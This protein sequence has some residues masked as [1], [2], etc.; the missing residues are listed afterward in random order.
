MMNVN[1]QDSQEP[2]WAMYYNG[3]IGRY[4]YAQDVASD[5]NGNVYVV[6]YGLES[7]SIYWDVTTLKYDPNGNLLWKQNYNSAW[8]RNDRGYACTVD[9]AG[10]IYVLGRTYSMISMDDFL[11]IKYDTNGNQQWVQT[12][13]GPGNSND[14]VNHYGQPIRYDNGRI[15]VTGYSYSVGTSY[16]ATT[17]CYDANS[18]AQ[19][20][21]HRYHGGW[22]VDFGRS[23]IISGG[24]CYITGLANNG[25]TSNDVLT[26]CYNKIS[27]AVIWVKTY[28][29]GLGPDFGFDITADNAGRVFVTG[30]IAARLILWGYEYDRVTIAYDGATGAQLWVRTFNANNGDN[31]GYGITTD[32][33]GN[34]YTTGFSNYPTSNTVDIVTI[35][36]DA[37]TGN[38]RWLAHYNGPQTL[39]S[40]EYSY[41]KPALDANGNV[42]IGG[43]GTNEFS[44]NDDLLVIAYDSNGNEQMIGRYNGLQNRDEY[45]YGVSVDPNGNIYAAGFGSP[46]TG[47]YYHYDIL[48]VKFVCAI[49]A[50]VEMEPQTLNLDSKGNYATVKVEGF[51]ENPKYSPLDVDG[52]TVEVGGVSTELK[53]GTWN[54]DKY[55]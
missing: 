45:C 25:L 16:D 41:C 20:W 11:I 31:L 15:Y 4:D 42:I 10:N 22:G 8:G 44:S 3:A 47:T 39:N 36:Y 9:P 6:G 2:Q 43:H 51:P 13:N 12:Y 38:Q 5:V 40:Y 52:A 55:I 19:L 29:G 28:H 27:G 1:A 7:S 21:I 53:F 33:S 24:F 17:I 54:N 49:P 46:P 48:T 26:I 35:A 50:S 14:H 18:G 32:E 30:H 37:P 23:V 34:V